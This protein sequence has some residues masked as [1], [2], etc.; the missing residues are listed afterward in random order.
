MM[1]RGSPR[2][3]D[4]FQNGWAV[5]SHWNIPARTVSFGKGMTWGILAESGLRGL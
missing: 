2:A 3:T 1:W 4:S 5:R